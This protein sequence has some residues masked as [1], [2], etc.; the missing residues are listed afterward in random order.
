MAF[1]GRTPNN[2]AARRARQR[3]YKDELDKQVMLQNM[4]KNSNR[5]DPAGSSAWNQ[6]ANNYPPPSGNPRNLGE[7][8]ARKYEREFGLN[9][10]RGGAPPPQGLD[11]IRGEIAERFRYLSRAFLSAD[12]DRS[13]FLDVG[14]IRRLC[15]LYNIPQT[16][17]D[18]VLR[19]ADVDG[20]G[21]ISYNEF[22][23]RLSQ[24]DY[25]G[26][27]M[28][29]NIPN[30]DG[31]GGGG[32][33]KPEN[34]YRGVLPSGAHLAPPRN[35]LDAMWN[36][37]PGSNE[38]RSK[39]RKKQ[40]WLDDLNRQVQ[41]KKNREKQSKITEARAEERARKQALAYNPYGRGGGGAPLRDDSGHMVT[42]L[43]EVH[44]AAK[45]GGLSPKSNMARPY[46][47]QDQGGQSMMAESMAT[48]SYEVNANT[49]RIMTPP[50]GFGRLAYLAPEQQREIQEADRKRNELRQTL[51]IQ[52]EMKKRQKQIEQEKKKAEERRE[53]TRVE[54]ERQEILSAYQREH[55]DNETKKAE[56]SAAEDAEK[57]RQQMRQQ[58]VQKKRGTVDDIFANKQAPPRT[59]PSKDDGS[60][61]PNSRTIGI[62]RLR[63]DLNKQHEALL[64]QLAEQRTTIASLQ[65]QLQEFYKG[66]MTNMVGQELR[67]SSYASPGGKLGGKSEF[68][69]FRGVDSE[70]RRGPSPT[71]PSFHVNMDEPD[72]L[73]ALLTAFVHRKSMFS[74][75]A[76]KIRR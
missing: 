3:Q 32:F 18:G 53:E 38:A 68:I 12:V 60:G 55:R 23:E 42:D 43:R 51:R 15:N 69:N 36:G 47:H 48:P 17:V 6:R 57:V 13:G 72:E 63:R 25:P 74:R 56:K 29:R 20:N 70:K 40:Q 7:D 62:G 50:G 39:A 2:V 24:P 58:S 73:D 65:N 31:Y 52:M 30:N 26:R 28:G 8:L 33:R 5:D 11:K 16:D 37:R 27:Q 4:K 41:E 1:I 21:R 35:N 14:E 45:T 61:N 75:S 76:K 44:G 34:S 59:P 46:V 9:N 10:N 71:Q 49:G 54:R 19:F 66:D 67:G 64:Q 22:A